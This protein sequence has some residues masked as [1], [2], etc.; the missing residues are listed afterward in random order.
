MTGPPDAGFTLLE[1]LVSLTLLAMVFAIAAAGLRFGARAWESGT[2]RMGDLSETTAVQRLIRQRLA[3]IYPLPSAARDGG[4]V[5]FDGSEDGIVF[6]ATLPDHFGV[7]GFYEVTIAP[8]R[9]GDG[10]DLVF[11]HRLIEADDGA[12]ATAAEARESLLL[13]DIA[14]VRMSY[15][16]TTAEEEVPRWHARWSEMPALPQLIRV[17]IDF[18][19]G[20]DRTWPPVV[21][22][23]MIDSL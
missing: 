6:A 22:A 2:A 5:F 1:L 23:P 21:V 7:G 12:A 16:G 14:G 11:R 20:D 10:T 8:A 19:D 17:E 3:G 4:G 13:E 18:A 15:Y 9:H